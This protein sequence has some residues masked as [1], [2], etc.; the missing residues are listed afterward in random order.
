MSSSSSSRRRF[1]DFQCPVSLSSLSEELL[2]EELFLLWRLRRF[3]SESELGGLLLGEC[4]LPSLSWILLLPD[5]ETLT[6]GERCRPSQ[7][8]I[9]RLPSL[10]WTSV[11]LSLS[12][13]SSEY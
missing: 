1:L 3:S 6:L 12:S 4:C 13:Y 2:E 7:S 8:S 9:L 11:C 10:A 5:F